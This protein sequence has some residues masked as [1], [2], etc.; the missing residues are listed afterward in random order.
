MRSFI[1]FL[2]KTHGLTTMEWVVLCAVVLL[3]AVAVTTTLRDGAG[4]L[5]ASVTS[6]MAC[7]GDG[8]CPP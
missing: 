1:S 2:R 6:R 4:R 5:G 3:G 8:N 7:D